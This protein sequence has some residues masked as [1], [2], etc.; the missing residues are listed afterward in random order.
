L[1]IST[2]FIFYNKDLYRCKININ[3]FQLSEKYAAGVTDG[4][5]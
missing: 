3:S 2:D 5:R 1:F 4:W